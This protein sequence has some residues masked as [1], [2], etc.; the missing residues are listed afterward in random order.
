[1]RDKLLKAVELQ[2]ARQAQ[3]KTRAPKRGT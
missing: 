2:A 1:V 3:R